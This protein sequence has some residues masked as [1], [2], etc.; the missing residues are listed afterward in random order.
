MVFTGVV[1]WA[2]RPPLDVAASTPTAGDVLGG[3]S[4]LDVTLV[5][6]RVMSMGD[7]NWLAVVIPTKWRMAMML[8]LGH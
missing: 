2:M 5:A 1:F 4:R 3:L 6:V 8:P 7:G